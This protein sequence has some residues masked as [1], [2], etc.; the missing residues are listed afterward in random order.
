MVSTAIRLENIRAQVSERHSVEIVALQP[1]ERGRRALG[2]LSGA[3]DRVRLPRRRRLEPY[4]AA[5]ILVRY[6]G[7]VALRGCPNK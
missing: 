5:Q 4:M 7:W 1:S 3:G 6:S 2:L